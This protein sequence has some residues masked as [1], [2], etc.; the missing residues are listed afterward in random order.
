M[1]Y[2]GIRTLGTIE[3][4]L[5]ARLLRVFGS[6][7]FGSTVPLRLIVTENDLSSEGSSSAQE[8][9]LCFLELTRQDENLAGER[10]RSFAGVLMSL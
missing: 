8:G 4:M 2:E 3:W 7:V 6:G 1:Y 10:P 9:R 5:S